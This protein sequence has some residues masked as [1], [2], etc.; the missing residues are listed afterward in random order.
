M[1]ERALETLKAL[2]RRSIDPASSPAEQAKAQEVLQKRLDELHLTMDDLLERQQ[3]GEYWFTYHDK[4]E[5]K[6]LHQCYA[7][8]VQDERDSRST[9]ERYS[10]GKSRRKT[11]ET[12]Y[13]LTQ[14]EHVEMKLLYDTYRQVWKNEI[15]EMFRAFC[16]KHRL[17]DP[18]LTSDKA[19]SVEEYLALLARMKGLKD[20]QDP[21]GR[22][23]E[24]GQ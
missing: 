5:E 11:R 9:W 20:V 24:Q 17:F 8:V 19:L 12:G 21:R 16:N 2:Y 10:T 13:E 4:I 18:T 3:L 6:I 15:D 7:A 23:L 1:T 22:L 14:A